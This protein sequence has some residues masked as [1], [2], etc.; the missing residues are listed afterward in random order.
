MNKLWMALLLLPILAGCG[1]GGGGSAPGTNSVV[2][3]YPASA[4]NGNG[5][6]TVYAG[7]NVNP[8]TQIG[9]YA[10]TWDTTA[11]PANAAV[12]GKGT[13][14]FTITSANVVTGQLTNSADGKV[15]PITGSFTGPVTQEFHLNLV[16]TYPGFIASIIGG[17]ATNYANHWSNPVPE[18]IQVP[19]PG[20]TFGE[21]TGSI[22]I[23]VW[24]H[25]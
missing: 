23:D 12:A 19:N 2:A 18:A 4:T 22:M 16:A 8:T 7:G 14:T 13:I 11:N 21:Q 15:Y 6:V 24:R 3:T 25:P 20:S 1:G 9:N 17:M 10:G 5:D